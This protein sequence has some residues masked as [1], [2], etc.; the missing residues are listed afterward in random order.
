M[1]SKVSRRFF[2]YGASG[3]GKVVVDA[4]HAAGDIVAFLVD[5]NA[6][7]IGC[8]YYNI[9]VL[10]SA[11]LAAQ[12]TSADFGV[13][14]I[15]N[16][17]TRQRI[18][19]MLVGMALP[20]GVVVHPHACVAASAS[21]GCGTAIFAG[22]V[23]NSDASI[24]EHAIINTLASVDHDCSIGDFSHIAPGVRLCGGVVVGES[25][26]MGVGSVVVPGVSIG[27][28]AIVG[29]GAVVTRD[30]P[31]GATVAGNPARI[32]EQRE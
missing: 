12:R 16:N 15:G 26:L 6:D 4:I 27:S 11:A 22:A 1:S 2:V 24:G 19:R 8:P 32:L 5:D 29:A 28:G 13:V 21:L 3:H 18:A 10:S 20:F 14:A 23:I 7:K 25:V 17:A 31:A 30:V 9:D